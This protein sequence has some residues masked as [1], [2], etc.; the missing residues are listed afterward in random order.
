K[1][2]Q[3]FLH[4]GDVYYSGTPSEVKERFLA[5]WP[6]RAGAFSRALNSNHEMYTGGH[7]YFNQT[8]KEFEQSSSCF[9]LQ[10]DHWL[11][12]RLDCAY[13]EH[14][15]A[16]NQGSWLAGLV[17]AAGKRKVVLFCHHQPYSLFESQG[18]KLVEKLDGL[19]S[20]G[21]IFAW[22]WGHE[23]RCVVYDK[24]PLWN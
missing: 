11:L 16:M 10:N 4:L 22:Y 18:P 7:A 19:L 9:A 6:R 20:A 15:F 14:D 3:L 5:L 23:H 21:R 12:V 17:A 24:H 1:G 13:Q 2:Y 8:L